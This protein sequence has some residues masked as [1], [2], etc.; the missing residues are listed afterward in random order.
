M[1][2]KYLDYVTDEHLIFCISEL[3]NSY[4]KAKGKITIDLGT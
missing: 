2:N 4:L 3:F 1:A